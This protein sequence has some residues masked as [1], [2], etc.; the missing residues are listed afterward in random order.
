VKG[1]PILQVK[2]TLKKL[3]RVQKGYAIARP[4]PW[5]AALA[6]KEAAP[7]NA[8]AGN[9]GELPKETQHVAD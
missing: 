9:A 2:R 7:L 8:R 6:D 3:Q 1:L 4:V 5:G